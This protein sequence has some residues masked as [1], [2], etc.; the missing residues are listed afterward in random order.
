[1]SQTLADGELFSAVFDTQPLLA[2]APEPVR[3]SP[4][5]S[6]ALLWVGGSLSI[7]SGA[8]LIGLHLPEV[9]R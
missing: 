3:R 9:L 4:W 5:L 6:E 7:L 2:P 8:L 1:V